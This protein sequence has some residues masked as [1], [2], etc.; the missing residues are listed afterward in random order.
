MNAMKQAILDAAVGE[1]ETPEP[2]AVM[3]HFRFTHDFMGFSG[4]FPGSPIL[5]A[6]VQIMTAQALCEKA[7]QSVLELTAVENA[8][9]LLPLRPRQIMELLCKSDRD[10]DRLVR[11]ARITIALGVAAKFKLVFKEIGA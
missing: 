7:E 1:L 5:P 9:F 6:F 8:K 4:H 10:A 3:Q 2:G 11:H